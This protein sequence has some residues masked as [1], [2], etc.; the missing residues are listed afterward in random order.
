MISFKNKILLSAA[1]ISA[2]LM[3]SCSGNQEEKVPEKELIFKGY[4]YSLDTI[5]KTKE[6]IIHNIELGEKLN[7]VKSKESKKPDE[8]DVD[9]CLYN[10]K[11]DSISNY[12]VAYNFVGDSLDEIEVQINSTSL[13]NGT[14]IL[15][16]IKKYYSD[17]YTAPLMDKGVYVFSCFDSKKRNFMI[18]IS[19]NSTSET[20]IINLLIYREK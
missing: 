9:Y 12:S 3:Y 4:H 1:F 6:G 17:K 14:V 11:I 19:D 10:Y 18:T 15:N 2:A 7:D 20:G 8:M 5:L 16:A 13:D